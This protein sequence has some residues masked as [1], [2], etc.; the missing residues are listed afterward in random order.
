ME[1]LINKYPNIISD[2]SQLI[3]FSFNKIFKYFNQKICNFK[4]E[5][6]FLININKSLFLKKDK[7]NDSNFIDEIINVM[8]KIKENHNTAKIKIFSYKK[9]V[10]EIIKIRKD[11]ENIDKKKIIDLLIKE[12]DDYNQSDIILSLSDLYTKIEQNL[13]RGKNEKNKM[14]KIIIINNES[15]RYNKIHEKNFEIKDIENILNEFINEKSCYFG[16]E[17]I[18]SNNSLFNNNYKVSMEEIIY[19]SDELWKRA[20]NL[21]NELY[22]KWQDINSNED[23]T[24]GIKK[25]DELLK[26]FKS[27]LNSIFFIKNKIKNIKE[28]KN[29]EIYSQKILDYVTSNNLNNIKEG[30]ISSDINESYMEELNSYKKMIN[31]IE[32]D[33]FFNDEIQNKKENNSISVNSVSKFISKQKEY[34]FQFIS[35]L[36]KSMSFIDSIEKEI[37]R[38]TKDIINNNIENENDNEIEKSEEEENEEEEI[39]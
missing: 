20:E 19:K 22:E 4:A 14:M 10:K 17:F 1:N 36:E 23:V 18:Y 26:F 7:S 37:F 6:Y 38:Q 39:K 33:A 13:I 35:V 8:N 11:D 2:F 32:M 30:I 3:K 9:Y 24:E 29:K 5:Y 34:I 15:E 21:N 16:V 12:I 28:E 25:L 31:E 27:V